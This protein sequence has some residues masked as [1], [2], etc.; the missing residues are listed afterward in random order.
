MFARVAP[1]A[2]IVGMFSVVSRCGIAPSKMHSDLRV[3]ITASSHLL[4]VTTQASPFH[5]VIVGRIKNNTNELLYIQQ[6]EGFHSALTELQKEVDDRWKREFQPTC[7]LRLVPPIQLPPNAVYTDTAVIPWSAPSPIFS[8]HTVS[9]IY[10]ALYLIRHS[11]AAQIPA[12]TFLGPLL[13]E[14]QRFSSPFTVTE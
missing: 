8:P 5:L 1:F 3:I 4:K 13:P 11:P 14:P 12:P 2:G 7:E 6:C 10:R 9:G